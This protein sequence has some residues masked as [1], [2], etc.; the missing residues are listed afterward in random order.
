MLVLHAHWQPPRNSSE[1]GSVLFW[2]E[3]SAPAP[4]EGVSSQQV[5]SIP[6]LDS[7]SAAP[8]RRGGN[9]PRPHPFCAPRDELMDLLGGGMPGSATLKMPS[10]DGR[11]LPSPNLISDWETEEEEFL[12]PT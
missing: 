5:E 1:S 3:T 6:P 2:A 12:R 8:R 9:L 10:V 4:S 11:P 7:R